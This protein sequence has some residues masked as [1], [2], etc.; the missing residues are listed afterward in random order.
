M[1]ILARAAGFA[2]AF[3]LVAASHLEAQSSTVRVTRAGGSRSSGCSPTA[4]IH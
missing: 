4:R 3:T 1:T 2:A